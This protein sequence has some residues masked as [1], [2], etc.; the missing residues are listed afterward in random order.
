V[1]IRRGGGVGNS[2]GVSRCDGEG[3]DVAGG[4]RSKFYSRY[5]YISVWRKWSDAFFHSATTP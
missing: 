5:R 1:V 2:G 3:Q 4:E